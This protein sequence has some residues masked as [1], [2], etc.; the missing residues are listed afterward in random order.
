MAKNLNVFDK[1]YGL[2]I[3]GEWTTGSKGE[4]MASYNPADGT[5]LAKFVDASNEDVDAAVKAAQEAFK[6]WKKTTAAERAL[7]LNQI[8]DIIDE[9]AE[10]FALQETLDNGKPIRETRAADIPLAS[11]HFRYFASVIRGEE[12]TCNQLDEEDLSIVLR[13]P[14][15]VV[16]QIIPWNFPFLM[17]AWKIAPALAAGCTIVIH[18][19]SSTSLSL[20]SFAQ[21]VNHLLPKGVLNIITGRGSKSGEY[22]LHHKGFNKLAF[23]GSTEIGRHVGIAAAEMLIP[24]TLELGGKSANIFFDD[25]PFDKALEGAQ[26][27]ILFNQGQVC[28]AG[29]RIFVQEGIYDKFVNALAEEF[30]KVKVGLPWEDDTQMG[31]Q[32]N[33]GQLETILKYVKIGEQEGARIITG[34]KKI[35]SGDL[36]KGE[37]VEPTL[38]AAQSNDDR[39]S[40]EEIFGPVATVIKFKTEEEV[41]KMANDS[42]Y[43]LGGAVWSKDINRCLRVSRALETGRVWVNCYNRL[44]AGAPFGGY[45][46]SGIGRET[47][48]MM[49]A[50]YTQVK[51]IYIST[52]E[53]RE[54]MY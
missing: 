1:E 48:K 41:I 52:R 51:N 2:L 39:I 9:N 30:K 35:E 8:A 7:I 54:G 6:T 4:L 28:C 53:E 45:K 14:I 27:G 34:G 49:L 26:K 44:P 18:P 17:A 5:E 21:K 19:S 11:D 22:M 36:G 25:M 46:T 33:A 43:G 31:A 40:Q 37:F 50:A 13:E 23:T 10:L 47:H 38:I 24:A 3:N 15:G 16:G 12:G 32:V 20:L 29:S 42:E